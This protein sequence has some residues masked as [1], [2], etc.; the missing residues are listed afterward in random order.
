[1]PDK[2]SG[3]SKDNKVPTGRRIRVNMDQPIGLAVT[4]PSAQMPATPPKGKE[5][6][7]T[8]GSSKGQGKKR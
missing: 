4:L 5:K 7:G 2:R 1:M 3:Q 8:N 6:G